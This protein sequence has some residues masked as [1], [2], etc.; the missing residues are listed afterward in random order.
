MSVLQASQEVP[1]FASYME[2]NAPG[3]MYRFMRLIGSDGHDA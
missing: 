2:K 1:E 3:W